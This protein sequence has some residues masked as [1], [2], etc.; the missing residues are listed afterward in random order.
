MRNLLYAAFVRRA[1]AFPPAAPFDEPAFLLLVG[2]TE[3]QLALI[4]VNARVG[5]VPWKIDAIFA[6]GGTAHPQV[7]A[8]RGGRSH[9]GDCGAC[10]GRSK[11]S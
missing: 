8:A 10:A 1:L 6:I 4:A 9:A 7:G 5:L 3:A 11:D 2:P